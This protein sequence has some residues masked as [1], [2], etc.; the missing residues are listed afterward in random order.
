[1]IN[2]AWI[3]PPMDWFKFNFDRVAKRNPDMARCGGLCRDLNGKWILGFTFNLGMCNFMVAKL[4]RA[5]HSW[6]MAWDGGLKLVI[7]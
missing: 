7:F 3:S 5:F 4:W 6:K 2:V 1:M